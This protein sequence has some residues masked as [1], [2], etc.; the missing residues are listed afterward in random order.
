MSGSNIL[1]W[2]ASSAIAVFVVVVFIGIVVLGVSH[3]VTFETFVVAA[4]LI[5]SG[6]ILT[7][8]VHMSF[9]EE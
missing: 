4:A 9:F 3:P 8:L 2:L 7:K 5:V 1:S 6:L